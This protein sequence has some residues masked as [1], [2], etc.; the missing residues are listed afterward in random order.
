[1]VLC[2]LCATVHA[3]EQ[4]P[5]LSFKVNLSPAGSFVAQ[6]KRLV[7]EAQGAGAAFQASEVSLELDSLRTGIELRDRHMTQKYMESKKFP[8]AVVKNAEG[9]DGR[10][11]AQLTVHGKTRPVEGTFE[12][13]GGP[14]GP[15]WVE[16]KFKAT[17]SEFEIEEANYMGVGV[18]DEVEV[19]ALV[20]LRKGAVSGGARK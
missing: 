3:A 14:S 13:K 15:N 9:K 11:K 2:V 17:L 20:P 19:T 18:E 6:S 7:G 4:A 10:F 12:I 5:L 1:M 8:T 16:A